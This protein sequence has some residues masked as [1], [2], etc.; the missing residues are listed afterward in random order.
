MRKI[1]IVLT[2]VVALAILGHSAWAFQFKQACSGRGY[3]VG[4]SGTTPL[5]F[6]V[7]QSVHF[8]GAGTQKFDALSETVNSNGTICLYTLDT[9][10]ASTATIN[11]DGSGTNVVFLVGVSG[12]P[13]GCA[14]SF[15]GHNAFVVTSTGSKFISADPWAVTDGD[16]L[17]V[18]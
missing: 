14:T 7:V 8:T 17:P 3:S 12:N 16:C 9:T 2:M 4:P 13:A 18:P 11:P 5:S 1:A 10:Q 15:T 6:T